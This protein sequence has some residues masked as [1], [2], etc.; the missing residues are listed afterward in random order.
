MNR[1]NSE[2]WHNAS[3]KLRV[4][5]AEMHYILEKAHLEEARANLQNSDEKFA[6][7]NSYRPM[8]AGAPDI[9]F[10]DEFTKKEVFQEYL[11]AFKNYLI[12][13]LE[14]ERL[15]ADLNK[16]ELLAGPKRPSLSSSGPEQGVPRGPEGMTPQPPA[17]PKPQPHDVINDEDDDQSRWKEAGLEAAKRV[18][19][20]IEEA[21]KNPSE[22]ALR[23]LVGDIA[24]LQL[25]GTDEEKEKK[26][27]NAAVECG[28]I[29]KDKSETAFRSTPTKEN[30]KKLLD[31]EATYQLL[32]GSGEDPLRGVKRLRPPGP[33]TVAPGDT[34]SSISKVFYGN[35]GYW[36]VIHMNNVRVI[37][38][39]PDFI[40]PGI[41]LQIP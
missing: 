28:G 22:K 31:R 9:K 23:G 15:S 19:R 4:N 41:T 40:N 27:M 34:L 29:L 17:P 8:H 37:G 18:E 21:K 24:V 30:F 33:Y 13:K 35:E 12:A 10:I 26:G 6:P 16:Q 14:Y 11:E 3:P 20:S 5:L 7:A 2:A 38:N 1:Y 25:Y 32:G 39:N 36:D